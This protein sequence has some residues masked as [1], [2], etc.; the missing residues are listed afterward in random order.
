MVH[1]DIKSPT[2]KA[3]QKFKYSN[4]KPND[5]LISAVNKNDPAT[6]PHEKQNIKDRRPHKMHESAWILAFIDQRQPPNIDYIIAH[7]HNQLHA[8][9]TGT[10]KKHSPHLN[11]ISFSWRC[12]KEREDVWGS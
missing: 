4:E 6:F 8:S 10:T 1:C 11:H 3:L 12:N 9:Q 5:W 7:L 2:F